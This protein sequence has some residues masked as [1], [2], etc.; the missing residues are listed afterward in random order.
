MTNEAYCI[1][2]IEF[3]KGWIFWGL[4]HQIVNSGIKYI[5]AGFFQDFGRH[6]DVLYNGMAKKE[7]SGWGTSDRLNDVDLVDIEYEDLF[8]ISIN[9]NSFP[10]IIIIG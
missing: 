10:G 6:H 4:N 8:I 7:L 5:P 1:P 3:Y 9:P 2:K